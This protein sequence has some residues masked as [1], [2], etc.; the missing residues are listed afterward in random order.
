MPPSY[1]F[2]VNLLKWPTELCKDKPV[3]VNAKQPLDALALS[4]FAKKV[5]NPLHTH[6]DPAKNLEEPTVAQVKSWVRRWG[7]S[8]MN[9]TD[10]CRQLTKQNDKNLKAVTME[11]M[12]KDTKINPELYYDITKLMENRDDN[13]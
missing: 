3:K 8:P 13:F 10:Q 9:F 4:I 2:I 6:K 5:V 7:P 11:P 12:K 1:N